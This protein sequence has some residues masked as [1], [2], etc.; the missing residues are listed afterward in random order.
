LDNDSS[1]TDAAWIRRNN[2]FTVKKMRPTGSDTTPP[3][4]S[5]PL[6]RAPQFSNIPNH[7]TSTTDTTAAE[8]AAAAAAASAAD[9][10]SVVLPLEESGDLRE[11]E[12]D[13]LRSVTIKEQSSTGP[14]IT[15]TLATPYQRKNPT[16]SCHR[17]RTKNSGSPVRTA[18]A[19]T[20]AP[21][22]TT[23]TS[24]VV[25]VDSNFRFTVVDMLNPEA[26]H[27]FSRNCPERATVAVPGTRRPGFPTK[28]TGVQPSPLDRGATDHVDSISSASTNSRADT[29]NGS[30]ANTL[31]SDATH[32]RLNTPQTPKKVNEFT[33]P[34]DVPS[35]A[36]SNTSGPAEDSRNSPRLRLPTTAISPVASATTPSS[37]TRDPMTQWSMRLRVSGSTEKPRTDEHQPTTTPGASKT[38]P[39]EKSTAIAGTGSNTATPMSDSPTVLTSAKPYSTPSTK[40]GQFFRRLTSRISRSHTHG[41][42]DEVKRRDETESQSADHPVAGAQSDVS[43]SHTGIR[44]ATDSSRTGSTGDL[45]VSHP[46]DPWTTRQRQRRPKSSA[47]TNKH[48]TISITSSTHDPDS[49]S[50]G[51]DARNGYQGESA[52]DATLNARENE[53][54]IPRKHPTRHPLPSTSSTGR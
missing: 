1:T 46:V 35:V 41:R 14:H 16:F 29:L 50:S 39:M 9:E 45:I 47:A 17:P 3:D 37:L 23:D 49:H 36:G 12:D 20:A 25:R 33:L 24:P 27:Q 44:L 18:A 10:D 26:R 19:P 48:A 22:P 13:T 6:S 43:E 31:N 42:T 30:S 8:A 40:P 15:T 28:R 21:N 52:D 4:Q 2:T 34:N 7:L 32:K 38:L 11:P 53:P 51:T 54:F 5:C